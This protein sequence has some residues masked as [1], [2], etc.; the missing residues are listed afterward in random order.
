MAVFKP[1]VQ[2]QGE[3]FPPRVGELIE[4]DALCRVISEAVD[5]IDLGAF[6]ANYSPLGRN[7]F[8]PHTMLKLLFFGY[9]TGVRSSRQLARN[10]AKDVEFMWLAGN[11]RP[12][13]TAIA[14]FR[15]HNLSLIEDLFV[16]VVHLCGE[17]GMTRCGQWAIDSSRMK[18]NAGKGKHKG[19]QAVENDLAKIRTQ[20][21]QALQ[22][23]ARADHDDDEDDHLPP[24]LRTKEERARRLEEA[25]AR[26]KDKPAT[27]RVNTT[28]PDAPMMKRK[29]GGFEPAY[30]PQ[31]TVDAQSQV[32]LAGDLVTD[33]NDCH[34]LVP[35]VEQAMRNTMRTPAQVLADSGYATGTN[36]RA[37]EERGINPLIPPKPDSNRTAGQF[38]RLDFLYEAEQ[39]C[40]IC[41]AGKTLGFRQIKHLPQGHDA[42]RYTC[43][44]CAGCELAA[45]CLKPG[46]RTRSL[47]VSGH[48]QRWQ[49]MRER[50]QT[51]EGRRDFARRKQSVE[52]VYGVLKEQM[53]FRQFLLRGIKKAKAELRLALTAF[54]I[55]KLWKRAGL[56]AL[57]S[58]RLAV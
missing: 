43:H 33:Q 14:D 18:A 41:P 58:L 52:P 17:L 26:L 9:A 55:R 29:G 1:H 53:G 5:Q 11:D 50:L 47:D 30:S 10:A 7:A 46:A 20:I 34:Q 44:D 25:K 40:F 21:A 32:V 24:G 3:M 19:R 35:Q 23:A 28:D 36:V 2:D 6:E 51:D 45:R 27:A 13:K 56:Q 38:T 48:D 57:K 16:Q 42:R 12:C 15:N 37:M 22:E 49:R 8:S 4:P 54:N 31:I 39:D